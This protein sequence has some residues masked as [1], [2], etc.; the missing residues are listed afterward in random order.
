M[1]I[2][3]IEYL[4]ETVKNYPNKVGFEDAES[5]LTFASFDLFAKNISTNICNTTSSIQ[6]P[7]GVFLPKSVNALTAFMGVLYS[8]NIYMPLDI[9]KSTRTHIW[10]FKPYT[11]RTYNYEPSKCNKIATSWLQLQNLNF[12]GNN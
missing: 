12:W 11:T 4:N 9:K 10:Y 1:K 3:V 7:I 2:N 5:S 8:G 6:K